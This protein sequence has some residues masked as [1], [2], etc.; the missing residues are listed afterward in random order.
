MLEN[1]SFSREEE[2]Q[3]HLEVCVG[4]EYE[5]R[6]LRMSV[7]SELTWFWRRME[8][9]IMEKKLKDKKEMEDRN[10]VVTVI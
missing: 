2:T 7:R 6:G 8:V 5:R 9:K 3:D 1:I 4:C 10:N